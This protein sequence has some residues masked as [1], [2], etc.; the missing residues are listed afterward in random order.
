MSF[1]KNACKRLCSVVNI[2]RESNDIHII[3]NNIVNNYITNII[4][5]ICKIVSFCG[6][7]TIT[8]DDI[9]IFHKIHNINLIYPDNISKIFN[10][11][12][13]SQKVI[14]SNRY[15]SLY[16]LKKPFDNMIRNIINDIHSELCV[17]KDVIILL[18]SIT[19]DYIINILK[20]SYVYKNKEGNLT[21]Q[22][23]EYCVNEFF[24]KGYER[25][26][27]INYLEK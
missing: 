25:F 11:N 2:K 13:N 19:E 1:N 14:E 26:N 17:G 10:S 27:Y 5:A 4:K 7:K 9:N 3:I 18:Q 21:F 16:T 20:K 23:I 24:S 8:K 22:N 15:Y 12:T 6:R